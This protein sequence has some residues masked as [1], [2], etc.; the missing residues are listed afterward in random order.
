VIEQAAPLRSA[1]TTAPSAGT[2]AV[3]RVARKASIRAISASRRILFATTA[4]GDPR[5]WEATL[6]TLRAASSD[7]EVG[8]TTRRNVSA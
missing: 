4:T 7:C 1:S 6:A 2:I 5:R 8:S 3:T